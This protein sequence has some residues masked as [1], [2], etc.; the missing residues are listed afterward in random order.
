[1]R[2]YDQLYLGAGG[3]IDLAAGTAEPESNAVAILIGLGGTGIDA[4]R[5]IKKQVYA[6]IR[7]DTVDGGVPQYSRIRFIG[8]DSDNPRYFTRPDEAGFGSQKRVHLTD[9]E[10]FSI[11]NPNLKMMFHHPQVLRGQPELSWMNWDALQNWMIPEYGSGGV[12]QIGR[13][14]M[15]DRSGHFMAR[16][17]REIR[18]AVQDLQEPWIRIH[19]FSGL[20]GGTGSGCFLDVCYMARHILDRNGRGSVNGYFYLPDVNL[21]AVPCSNTPVRDILARNAYA[22][23]QELDYCMQ[24]PG[25]GGAFTQRYQA[26]AIGWDRPP[27][28]TCF[29][30]G[31]DNFPGPVSENAYDHAMDVTAQA[32]LDFLTEGGPS[33]SAWTANAAHMA[34]A[35]E[36]EHPV[37]RYIRYHTI[38]AIG[39]TIPRREL[40]TYFAGGLFERF[41]GISTRSPSRKDAEEFAIAALAPDAQSLGEIYHRLLGQLRSGIDPS[42]APYAGGWKEV[43]N[44]GNSQMVGAYQNQTLAKQAALQQSSGRMM[45]E[46][47]PASLTARVEA[48]LRELTYDIHYGPMYAYDLVS[49]KKGG[50]PQLIYGL[51]HENTVRL[52]QT[53]MLYQECMKEYEIAR[54]RFENRKKRNVF[55]SDARR[56]EEYEYH[57]LDLQRHILDMECYRRMEEVLQTLKRQIETRVAQYHGRLA[58]VMENL[59]ETFRGNQYYLQHCVGVQERRSPSDRALV[60]L[61]DLKGQLD[62]EIAQMD[63]RAVFGDFMRLMMDNEEIWCSNDGDRI[64]GAVCGFVARHMRLGDTMDAL[65]QKKLGLAGLPLS[66]EIYQRVILPLTGDALPLFNFDQRVWLE[67]VSRRC[68]VLSV[69]AGSTA[70]RAAA[71]QLEMTHP[72]WIV[73]ESGL[74]DRIGAV[75]VLSGFPLGAAASVRN[76]RISDLRPRGLYSYEGKPNGDMVFNDWSKLPALKETDADSVWVF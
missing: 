73:R 19:I 14:L 4:I 1:M 37:D 13:F 50:L 24:L 17:E 62:A 68:A 35:V 70:I 6:H 7:P 25:N 75:M 53:A 2:L 52:E 56:F 72:E 36:R 38:G 16:L 64:A 66:T 54:D 34:A 63:I 69:P 44:F 40:D 3:G 30:L 71:G 48:R 12:R 20:A 32:F 55:E 28:D 27:V 33:F 23:M 42:Y 43:L 41:S 5:S 29:L 76:V 8:V 60:T 74:R 15:M 22:A 26:A 11:A 45:A 67:T 9:E 49:P 59:L 58:S 47:D 57:L 46:D 61:R 51:I 18:M 39:A 21:S 65:L 31:A 10:L